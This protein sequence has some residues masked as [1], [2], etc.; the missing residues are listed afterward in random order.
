MSLRLLWL[1]WV[2]LLAPF[3]SKW[4]LLSD[5][6]LTL[7][8]L[9]L[10]GVSTVHLQGWGLSVESTTSVGLGLLAGS[11]LFIICLESVRALHG[12]ASL[13]VALHWGGR[14]RT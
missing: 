6:L 1:A 7:L 4:T 12:I 8:E 13:V 10:F 3:A 11:V 14:P 9:G 2:L 5:A